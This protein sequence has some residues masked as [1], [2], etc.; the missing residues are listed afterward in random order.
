[1]TETIGVLLM[2]YGGPDSL[3]DIPAYLLDIRGGRS[4]S[5]ELIDEITENYRLIGGKSPLLDITRRQAALVEAKLN[6]GAPPG[7]HFK[8]YIGMRHWT[9]WIKD[10]VDQMVA[11][12]VQRAV[13]LVLAPHYSSMSIARYFAKLD[14]ALAGYERPFT[15]HAVT[16]Y[17]D[18][19]LYLEA[20]ARR[21]NTGLA[22]M[23]ADTLVIFSAHSLPARII[24]QGDPYDRQLRETAQLVADKVGLADDQWTFSYQSAGRS[25]E[26][27]LGPQ[28]QDYVVELAEQG[29]K[30]MLS[31]V[32]GFVA[33][34]VEILF[35]IDIKA[36]QAAERAGARL[37]RVPSLNDDPLF[38]AALADVVRGALR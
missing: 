21:V 19:P 14:E 30:N 26:P 28:I 12:G 4:T 13:A 17:Y 11:D 25:P 33:D 27:W 7:V 37:V 22:N 3:D 35:D 38:I 15:Y 36:K 16:S 1:M 32:V 29:H 9:P 34:H 23:P 24:E 8:T 10:A 18:H 6:A 31:C 2:A 5:Q 20:L